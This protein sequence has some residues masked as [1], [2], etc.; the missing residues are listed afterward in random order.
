M[1]HLSGGKNMEGA[2][3]D[4]KSAE[5]AHLEFCIASHTVRPLRNSD[6]C[7][8]SNREEINIILSFSALFFSHE[9]HGGAYSDLP[10][11]MIIGMHYILAVNLLSR[12]KILV[13]FG[14]IPK[15]AS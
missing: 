10:L 9:T 15:R 6:L 5:G 7:D 2:L 4:S 8:W 14:C 11:A 13:H 3:P 12:G 1:L